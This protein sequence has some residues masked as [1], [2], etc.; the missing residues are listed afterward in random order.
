MKKL[1]LRR[2][3][4]NCR[5]LVPKGSICPICGSTS[6]SSRWSGYVYIL[7]IDSQIAQ[8]IEAKSKGEYAII[9]R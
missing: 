4:R 2:A 9:I 5:Y 3:C 7:D 1:R 6:L 8:M